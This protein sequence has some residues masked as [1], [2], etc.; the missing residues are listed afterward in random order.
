MPV[1]SRGW[2]PHHRPG[3]G[4]AVREAVWLG[5]AAAV[6]GT[7]TGCGGAE[8]GPQVTVTVTVTPSSSLRG[9][10]PDGEG[11]IAGRRHDVGTIV[12]SR[13]T[14]AKQVLVLDRWS[15]R[16]VEDQVVGRDGVRVVPE[17]GDRFSNANVDKLYDVPVGDDLQ[18][19]INRCLEPEDPA[20]AP[21]MVS[22]PASLGEFL[23]LPD[24]TR[25]VVLLEYAGGRLVRLETSPRCPARR[26]DPAPTGSPAT[27]RPGGPGSPE[28][29]RS[30]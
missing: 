3:Q 12:R 1:R 8:P 5:V 28:P 22:R 26:A 14:G 25:V 27:G 16:G 9:A 23:S 21:G 6:G 15:V 4:A 18:V 10:K 24:R 30:R 7:L 2:T 17:T 13:G 19:V 29:S 11:S 20:A